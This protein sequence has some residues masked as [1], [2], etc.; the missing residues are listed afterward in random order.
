[1]KEAPLYGADPVG[2]LS[3]FRSARSVGSQATGKS[4]DGAADVDHDQEMSEPVRR[5]GP[6]EWRLLRG[7][8]LWALAGA[9]Y[10]FGF[11][12]EEEGAREDDVDHLRRH[13]RLVRGP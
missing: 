6:R 3:G 10:A 4:V 11:T 12:R 9:P 1:M 2:R 7:V 5:L 13:A 8:R